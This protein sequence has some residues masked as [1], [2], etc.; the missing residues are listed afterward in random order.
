MESEYKAL[1]N[2]NTEVQNALYDKLIENIKLTDSLENYLRPVVSLKDFEEMKD[3]L[4]QIANEKTELTEK[5]M[6]LNR[7]KVEL[8]KSNDELMTKIEYSNALTSRLK[9]E[10]TDK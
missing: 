7:K 1:Y 3:L 4:N 2:N 8:H 10:N 6:D 9:V 5:Y